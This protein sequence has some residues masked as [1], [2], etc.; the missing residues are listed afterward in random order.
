MNQSPSLSSVESTPPIVLITPKNKKL[1]KYAKPNSIKNKAGY[2]F[3]NKEKVSYYNDTGSEYESS[4]YESS[5]Y[6]SSSSSSSSGNDF[7]IIN[8]KNKKNID[9]DI[10]KHSDIVFNTENDNKTNIDIDIENALDIDSKTDNDDKKNDSQNN[11]NMDIDTDTQTADDIVVNTVMKIN[12]NDADLTKGIDNTNVMDNK[13]EENY[14]EEDTTQKLL[15][16]IDEKL[17]LC[18]MD[19]DMLMGVAS[20]AYFL[21]IE[22]GLDKVEIGV[23]IHNLNKCKYVCMGCN[24]SRKDQPKDVLCCPFGTIK[25]SSY[26]LNSKKD[27]TQLKEHIKDVTDNTFCLKRSNF[28]IRWINLDSNDCC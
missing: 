19:L 4:E 6:E 28:I 5:K 20:Y 2:Q 27:I 8:N 11:D 1:M 24:C 14:Y 7:I 25:K 9:I 10:E 22:F 26:Y 21:Y 13:M 17:L 12:N 18:E 23:Q 3:R 16:A 15:N